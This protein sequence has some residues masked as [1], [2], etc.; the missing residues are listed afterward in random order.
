MDAYDHPLLKK[1]SEPLWTYDAYLENWVWR[2][3]FKQAFAEV[4]RAPERNVCFRISDWVDDHAPIAMAYRFARRRYS[5]KVNFRLPANYPFIPR[6]FELAHTLNSPIAFD[7]GQKNGDT[8][9][10]ILKPD[11]QIDAGRLIE[12]GRERYDGSRP[13]KFIS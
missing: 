13:L 8:S 4:F 10:L 11:G 2:G 7:V 9:C 5:L 3:Q 1:L 6:I 12:Y